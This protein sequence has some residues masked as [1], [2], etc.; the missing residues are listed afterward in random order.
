M[1]GMVRQ[2]IR[3]PMVSCYRVNVHARIVAVERNPGKQLVVSTKWAW[4]HSRITAHAWQMMRLLWSVSG[5]WKHESDRRFVLHGMSPSRS[6]I[7]H[8]QL[9]RTNTILVWRVNCKGKQ[10]SDMQ[11]HAFCGTQSQHRWPLATPSDK[12]GILWQCIIC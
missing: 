8:P 1:L 11:Q 10:A 7:H 5:Q 4:V 6:T 3:L 12:R 2:C 9:F